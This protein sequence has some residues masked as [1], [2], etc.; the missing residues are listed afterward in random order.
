M[1]ETFNLDTIELPENSEIPA[2][3]QACP[4]IECLRYAN[5]EFLIHG[6]DSAQ[7]IFLLLRGHCL[8][9]QP[10]APRER[11]PGNEL[12]VIQAE[13]GAPVFVGEMAYLGDGLRTASVR[14]VM[15]TFTLRLKPDHLDTIMDRFPGFTRILCRQ[16]ALRL[17]EANIYIK[18]YQKNNTM[19]VEQRFLSPGDVLVEEGATADK[20][21]QL[22]DGILL[23]KGDPDTTIRPS[24]DGPVFIGA[25]PFFLGGVHPRRVVARTP[26]IIV[27]LGKSREAAIIRNFPEL[28]LDLIREI[29]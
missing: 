24:D 23:E 21:F 18:R 4:D 28:V 22:I 1:P 16:F 19:A 10:D 27:A 14:S 20:L 2:L 29:D 25:R 26:A 12:A 13:P 15:A 9:E 5:D 7:D 3:I 6:T 11:T 8:V 17:G